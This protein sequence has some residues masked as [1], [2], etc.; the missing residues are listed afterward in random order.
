MVEKGRES[1]SRDW[2]LGTGW[3]VSVDYAPVD[4]KRISSDRGRLESLH[5][6]IKIPDNPA[7]LVRIL[8]KGIERSRHSAGTQPTIAQDEAQIESSL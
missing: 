2:K 1:V 8:Q 7:E 6:G 4:A 3:L 5:P